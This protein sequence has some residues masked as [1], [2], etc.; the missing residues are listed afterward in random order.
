MLCSLIILLFICY[1]ILFPFIVP[2]G[3]LNQM[4]VLI[5][6]IFC[7]QILIDSFFAIYT[8]G[9]LG[10]SLKL[11]FMG[12]T[13]SRLYPLSHGRRQGIFIHLLVLFQLSD[14]FLDYKTNFT[15]IKSLLHPPPPPTKN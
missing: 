3:P 6:K 9:I 7:S 15:L 2:I 5:F 12:I 10:L 13:K 11:R 14:K 4:N 1:F 8:N